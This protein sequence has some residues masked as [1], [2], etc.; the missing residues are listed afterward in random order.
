MIAVKG[1]MAVIS[2][3]ASIFQVNACKLRRLFFWK[4]WIWKNYQRKVAHHCSSCSG[5]TGNAGNECVD[6]A[7]SLAKKGFVSEDNVPSLLPDRRILVQ[8]LLNAPHCLSRIAESLHGVCCPVSDGVVCCS[9]QLVVRCIILLP[10]NFLSTQRR[11]LRSSALLR[12]KK[13][14]MRMVGSPPAIPTH[15]GRMRWCRPIGKK[16]LSHGRGGPASLSPWLCP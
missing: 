6:G 8:R 3:G 7:A 13:C 10:C 1:P 16:S 9:F 11:F 5:H 4:H 15:S 2:T 12:F 14:L